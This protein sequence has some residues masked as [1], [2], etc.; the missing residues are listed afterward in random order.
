MRRAAPVLAPRFML[1][2]HSTLDSALLGGAALF[3][4]GWGLGGFCP[5]PALVSL[6]TATP[7]VL[8]FVGAMLA[9][10]WLFRLLERHRAC[11]A[12]DASSTS[13][14]THNGPKDAKSP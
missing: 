2:Q 11:L 12:A 6:T 14:G 9:G 13:T 7:A 10:M 5:G 1:P 3:G 4:V 8:T